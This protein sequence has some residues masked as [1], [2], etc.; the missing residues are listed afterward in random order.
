M[1]DYVRGWVS[2]QILKEN[3]IECPTKSTAPFRLVSN[4]LIIPVP[5]HPDVL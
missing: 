5:S 4:M 2:V 3:V 1:Q